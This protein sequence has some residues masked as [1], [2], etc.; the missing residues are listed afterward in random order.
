MRLV[1]ESVDYTFLKKYI[2][3]FHKFFCA[4]FLKIINYLSYQAGFRKWIELVLKLIALIFK[5]K[6][7]TPLRVAKNQPILLFETYEQQRLVDLITSNQSYSMSNSYLN[8]LQQKLT[9]IYIAIEFNRDEWSR[10]KT[11]LQHFFQ[12]CFSFD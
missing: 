10:D 4:I 1:L 7:T 11:H 9:E 3:I 12:K 6:S 2:F 8:L 5:P